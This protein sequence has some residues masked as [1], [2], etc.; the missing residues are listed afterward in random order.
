MLLGMVPCHHHNTD[1]SHSVLWPTGMTQRRKLSAIA[2]KGSCIWLPLTVDTSLHK[3]YFIFKS[4][5]SLF[6]VSVSDYFRIIVDRTAIN[7]QCPIISQF[8]NRLPLV[9]RIGC[10]FGLNRLANQLPA[11]ENIPRTTA[12][13]LVKN[14][15]HR[16][17]LILEWINHLLPLRCWCIVLC[18]DVLLMKH[19]M[20]IQSMFT[21]NLAFFV[22]HI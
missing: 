14:V 2:F 13:W 20:A 8:Y 17:F 4:S 21:S 18:C 5:S 9:H 12:L 6:S 7:S 16:C 22:I 10:N 11:L 3:H 19:G 15:K 1:V